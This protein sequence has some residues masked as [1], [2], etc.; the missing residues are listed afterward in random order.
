[1]ILLFGGTVGAVAAKV[2][3]GGER[4]LEWVGQPF[5]MNVWGHAERSLDVMDVRHAGRSSRLPNLDF[6]VLM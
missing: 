6:E 2:Q 5:T 4:K 3:R 1:L